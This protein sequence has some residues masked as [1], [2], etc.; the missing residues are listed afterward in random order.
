M[1]SPTGAFLRSAYVVTHVFLGSKRHLMERIFTDQNEPRLASR[2]PAM[3]SIGHWR[4]PRATRT[5]RRS[6]A[7]SPGRLPGTRAS[8]RHR[9][10]S[11]ARSGEWSRPENARYTTLWDQLSA[12]QRLVLTALVSSGGDGVLSEEYRRHNRLTRPRQYR[13]RCGASSSVSS[14]NHRHGGPTRCQMSSF[15]RGLG[16]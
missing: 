2:S 5:I 15:E 4:S 10:S 16:G 12:H 6:S 14:S 9:T 8:P 13:L 7:I 1:I 3:P 11:T